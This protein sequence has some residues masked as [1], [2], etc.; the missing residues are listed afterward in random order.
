MS[1]L[2]R[3]LRVLVRWLR[4]LPLPALND[5]YEWAGVLLVAAALSYVHVGLAVG[6]AGMLGDLAESLF[7]RDMGRKDS[8]A[9]LPGFGGILDLLDSVLLAAPVAYLL[10]VVLELRAGG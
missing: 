7:K 2:M 10:W 9:W 8:S 5:V 3:V 6:V 4:A 1:T